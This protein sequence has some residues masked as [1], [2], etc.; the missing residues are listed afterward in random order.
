M[1]APSIHNA[2]DDAMAGDPTLFGRQDVVEAAWSI[3]D[4]VIH[5]PSAMY[6]Y[7]PGSWGPAEADRLVQDVGGWNTP[8]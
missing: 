8:Q 4:P 5:C 6:E 1:R 7:E 3:V 2:L